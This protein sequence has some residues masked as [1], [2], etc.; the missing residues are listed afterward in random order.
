V[1][2]FLCEPPAAWGHVLVVPR[3]HVTDIWDVEE[4]TFQLVAAVAHRLAH[5]LRP[6]LGAKG[7]NVRQN[8]G[9]VAG[10]DVFHFHVHVI[11]RYEGDTLGPF[12]VWKVPPWQAPEGGD[13]KRTEVAEAIRSALR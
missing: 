4:G 3:E 6:A 1:A 10:Q 13:E 9:E 8:S 12:C 7:I 11:P 2:A 5:A